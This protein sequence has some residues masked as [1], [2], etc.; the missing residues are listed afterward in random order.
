LIEAEKAAI[1][2]A[3]NVEGLPAVAMSGAAAG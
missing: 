3:R 2:D 1:N